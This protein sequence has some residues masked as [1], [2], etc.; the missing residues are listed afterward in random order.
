[1]KKLLLGLIVLLSAAGLQ[2]GRYNYVSAR[3]KGEQIR[4]QDLATKI[5]ALQEVLEALDAH[6]ESPSSILGLCRGLSY[7]DYRV[8]PLGVRMDTLAS[9]LRERFSFY[10][11]EAMGDDSDE[12]ALVV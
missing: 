3:K 5:A 2:A 4:S 7:A 6:Q 8:A 9:Y 1:M 10:L 11:A 12:E